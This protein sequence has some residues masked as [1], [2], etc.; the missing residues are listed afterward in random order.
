MFGSVSKVE[1]ATPMGLISKVLFPSISTFETSPR[2]AYRRAG[3][4]R[5]RK[6]TS[7]PRAKREIFGAHLGYFWGI[8]VL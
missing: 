2:H 1:I 4:R 8:F 3:S 5:R 7:P 6:D